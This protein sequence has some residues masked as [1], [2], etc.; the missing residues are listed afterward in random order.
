MIV[1]ASAEEFD[2]IVVGAG[3]A[4]SVMASRLS[5]S[6]DVRVLLIEAGDA[7]PL[8]DMALPPA[9]PALQGTTADWADETVIQA[10]TGRAVPWPR[11]RGLG[12]SSSINAMFF[13]RGNR[14]SYDAWV[15]AGATGWSFADLLPFFKQSENLSGVPGRDPALRGMAGPMR[16]GPS[17]PRHPVATAGL[18]AIADAGYPVVEDVSSGAEEGFGWVDLSILDGLR[19]SAAD[20]YLRPVLDRN[21]LTVTTN[22]L[23]TQLVLDKGRCMGVAYRTFDQQHIARSAREVVLCAGAIGSP[24]LLT[25]SGVGPADDLIEH[26]IDVVA[27]LPGVGANL[28]DHPMSGIVYRSA[29]PVPPTVNTRSGVMGVIRSNPELP[30]PDIQIRIT[31]APL[32]EDFSL[33][34]PTSEGYTIAVSLMAPHSRGTVRLASPDPAA[35][36]VIDPRYYTDERDIDAMVAGLRAARSIG[37]AAGLDEWR[38]TEALPGA[39]VTSDRDLRAYIGRNLLTYSH[40]A[41][42]CRIGSDRQSVVDSELRV[43]GVTGLR[44]ADA[45]V[46]PT[47]ISANT[48]ATVLAIAERAADLIKG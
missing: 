46:M 7:D 18:A 17:H 34:P 48:N 30:A 38:A 6:P 40:Y 43:N 11:G 14:A 27:D 21:N 8:P 3:S 13:V 35:R 28:H 29:Q 22:A 15:A 10:V 47:P 31:N 19:Q 20:A 45:S 25:L 5:E 23:A 4:G 32:A 36:P 12:G 44:I 1:G 24:Q 37:T 16:P 39:A 2:Y 26:G 41:G 9:W 33:L 42:T